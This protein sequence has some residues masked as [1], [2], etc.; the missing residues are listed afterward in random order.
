MLLKVQYV[1]FEHLG[2]WAAYLIAYKNCYH[3]AL[4]DIRKGR[5]I[6]FLTEKTGKNVQNSACAT[7]ENKS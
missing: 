7:L 2:I 5:C 6:S 1:R 3:I 4:E